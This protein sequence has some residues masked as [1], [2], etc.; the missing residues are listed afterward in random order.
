MRVNR[1]YRS[2][3]MKK[4]LSVLALSALLMAC[5]SAKEENV[6]VKEATQKPTLEVKTAADLSEDEIT[7]Y[8]QLEKFAR[9][10]VVKCNAQIIPNKRSPKVEKQNNM[11]VASYVEFD[12]ESV[13]LEIIP[14]PHRK[15]SYLAKVRYREDKYQC[16]AES[17]QSALK[18]NFSLV[19]KR[20]VTE[21]P[22]YQQGQ[23]KY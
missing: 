22:K 17:K 14:T 9:N 20:F 18:G 4:V 11:Y 10:H 6:Q 2:D 16:R 7:V 12:P 13:S 15:Y 23:W 19:G 5:T 3:Y 21:V 8:K 1:I